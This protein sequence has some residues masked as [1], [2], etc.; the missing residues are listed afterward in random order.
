MYLDIFAW[1]EG[2]WEGGRARMIIWEVKGG[3]E[4]KG[5]GGY[6]SW[7]RGLLFF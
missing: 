3:Q 4:E 7:W 6:N 2:R 5:R 1:E